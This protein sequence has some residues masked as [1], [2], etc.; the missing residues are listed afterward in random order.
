MPEQSGEEV[1]AGEAAEGSLHSQEGDT[2]AAI[3]PTAEGEPVAAETE[4]LEVGALCQLPSPL[5]ALPTPLNPAVQACTH[6]LCSA[7]MP[8]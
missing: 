3:K 6:S 1:E 8:F 4:E 5:A 2:E 7:C